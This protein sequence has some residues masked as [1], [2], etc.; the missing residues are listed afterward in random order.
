[1]D[2]MKPIMPK[3]D[4]PMFSSPVA[5]THRLHLK[6]PVGD[7]EDY[8]EWIDLIRGASPNDTIEFHLNTPGGNVYTAIEL[9]AAFAESEAHV[10]VVINGLCASAGTMLMTVGDSFEISPHTTFMFHTYSGGSVGK[11]NE[12]R[13]KAEYEAK[14]AETFMHDV[15]EGLL[16]KEEIDAML[17][18]KD[19]WWPATEVAD[20]LM[21]MVEYRQEKMAKI[22]EEMLA[23]AEEEK[24]PKKKPAKRKPRAKKKD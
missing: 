12:L 5:F 23:E 15:Y 11:G 3:K 4:K 1:M 24:K 10:H 9:M 14:W 18:G 7:S 22:I 2:D 17:E 6:G 19:Y 20:R 13:L 16:T 21:Q 8:I